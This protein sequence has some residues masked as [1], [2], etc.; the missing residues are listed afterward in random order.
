MT[1]LGVREAPRRAPSRTARTAS[2]SPKLRSRRLRERLD[3]DGDG[4]VGGGGK[5]GIAWAVVNH[6]KCGLARDCRAL[7][8]GYSAQGYTRRYYVLIHVVALG[9]GKGRD[10][11]DEPKTAD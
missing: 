2:T 11:Q 5:N 4:D 1:L 8:C 9:G 7:R 3:E 10:V 6:L